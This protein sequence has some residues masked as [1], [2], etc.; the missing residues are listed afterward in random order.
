MYGGSSLAVYINGVAQELLHLVCATAPK[1]PDG[2]TSE[3][4]RS[5]DEL[6]ETE[7]VYRRLGQLAEGES[8]SDRFPRFAAGDTL[9]K[10]GDETAPILTRFVVDIISGTSAGGINGIY[11]AK[12]LAT[13]RDLASLKQLWVEEGDIGKLI[14]D[15][16]SVRDL[17]GLKVEDPPASLLNGARMYWRLLQAFE[18]MDPAPPPTPIPDANEDPVNSPLA[19]QLDLFVTTTD[20]SGLVLPIELAD[21]VIGEPRH[22]NVYHFLYAT[23]R[24]SGDYRNDFVPTFNPFL[25]FAARCTSSLPFVFPPMTL[26]SI[27][28][29]VRQFP[30]FQLDDGA[31][32]A[33]ERWNRFIS[34]YIQIDADGNAVNDFSKRAFGDGG[35]LDNAPFSYA[36]DAMFRRRA[37]IRVERKLFY[38]EPDPKIYA[39]GQAPDSA[40]D[41]ITNVLGQGV[42]LPRTETIREDLMRVLD[43]NRQTAR[44]RRVLT[45]LQDD[46]RAFPN[47]ETTAP[48]ADDTVR[49]SYLDELIPQY[50]VAYGTYQRL[51]V[52]ELTDDLARLFCRLAG[53]N[54]DS[55][56]FFAVRYLV[57]AW[58]DRHFAHFRPNPPE[59]PQR[60]PFGALL[61]DCD[62][63]FELR[64]LRHLI[65]ET[66]AL[67]TPTGAAQANLNG[68]PRDVLTEA[69]AVRGVA[70][71]GAR[72]LRRLGRVLRAPDQPGPLQ[73]RVRGPG[74]TGRADQGPERFC[75]PVPEGNRGRR[76]PG[77]TRRRSWADGGPMDADTS[78]RA[79]PVPDDLPR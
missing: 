75:R 28:A 3:P 69:L 33:S 35:A 20:L 48:V 74:T 14:N 9:G 12:A 56:D 66:D 5:D 58:R 6:R 49:A 76:R 31:K 63:P 18:G 13:N 40:P 79:Q 37:D 19:D 78:R 2:L 7:G 15:K 51:R 43:R 30:R 21:K 29:I 34:D 45:P 22:R 4:L 32:A 26:D 64:R 23:E 44:M 70:N 59:S 52:A 50:G 68:D 46:I 11:L 39:F 17:P 8:V 55:D 1:E 61:L 71:D 73:P 60:D 25:A 77:G 41:A 57:R 38:I 36:I 27:D 65:A 54:E 10:A 67:V 16:E 62:I 42:T 24:A 72:A 47:P 53:L